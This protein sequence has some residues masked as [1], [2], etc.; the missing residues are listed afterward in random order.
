MHISDS[1]HYVGAADR[2][3]DLFEGQYAVPQ[4]I[5]Y[6]SYLIEDEKAAVMDTVDARKTGPWLENLE[7]ALKGRAP[8]YLIVSHLEPDHGGSIQAL[9]TRYPQMR[10]VLSAKALAMLPQFFDLD[11]SARAVAVKEGDTL[12]LGKHKL[13]FILAPMVHWPE[14]MVSYEESEGLLFSADAFG[15][16]GTLDAQEDW[17]AEARRYF[18]NIVGKYGAPVQTL[19]KKASDLDIHG[20]CPLHGPV[21]KENL[22][23]YL[24]KYQAWSSYTPEE[25]GTLVAYGTLH[26][27]TAQAARKVAEMLRAAGEKNVAVMDLAR[28][29]M[30]QAV[31]QAFR[32]DKMVL[33]CPTY[34]GGIFPK[35]EDFLLHLKAK[36]YQKRKVAL[37]ENGSWAPSAAKGMKT[38]L[39]GMKDVALCPTVVTIKSTLKPETIQQMEAMVQELR[40]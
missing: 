3:I 26:G 34:E 22:G 20:I 33:A 8:D 21:L 2:E 27:N 30:A 4:G 12:C 28:D 36:N 39:E 9:A 31:A 38:Y 18:I 23:Y 1:I 24:D 11:F 10:L 25:K 14:V 37:V 7:K 29:D 16:F 19:L 17:L 6:N 5:T 35:M 32:F 13:R 15:T 40:A